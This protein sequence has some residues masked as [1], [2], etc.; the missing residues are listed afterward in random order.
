[1]IESRFVVG[2]TNIWNTKNLQAEGVRAIQLEKAPSIAEAITLAGLNWRV[3]L[4]SI[5]DGNG[6]SIDGYFRTMRADTSATLGVVQSRYRPLQNVDAFASFQGLIDSGKMTLETAGSLRNGQLVWILGK[7]W[8]ATLSQHD[9]LVSYLCLSNGHNGRWTLKVQG[10]T[11]RVE[12]HNTLMQS[13]AKGD[14]TSIKHT[15]S[16]GDRLSKEMQMWESMIRTNESFAIDCQKMLDTMLSEKR[17]YEY[18]DE[19]F[20]AKKKPTTEKESVMDDLLRGG[21]VERK[22]VVDELLDGRATKVRDRVREIYESQDK[23]VG[24]ARGTAWRAYQA[25][26]SYLSHDASR[27]ED[28]AKLKEIVDADPKVAEAH[29]LL[30]SIIA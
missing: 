18:F 19:L 30:M 13:T 23:I 5:Y 27:T 2:S 8:E 20:V 15:R 17:A 29:R 7:I 16:I 9:H 11:T 22:Q 21:S 24:G 10:T 4:D 3:A 12:C 26:T 28:G 1:M 14:F 6:R 25:V